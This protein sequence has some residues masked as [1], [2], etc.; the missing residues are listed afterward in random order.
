MAGEPM[1][2]TIGVPDL[3][4]PSYFPAIAAVELGFFKQRGL[5][6]EIRTIFP[7]ADTFRAQASGEID[8]VAG[9][10]H[11]ALYEYR[12]WVGCRLV[13]ALSQNMY[14]FL[15]VRSD[16]RVERGELAGVVGLRI[17]AAPGPVDGLRE[18]LRLAGIDPDRDVEIVPPKGGSSI[19]FGVNAARS[20]EDG[21]VDAFWA[22]GMGARVAVDGG[23]GTVVIDARRGDGPG[24]S[25]DFTFPALVATER[26]LV[27]SADM[28]RAAVGAVTDA[29]HALKKE[30]ERAINAA[31]D[32]FP[33]SEKSQISSLV[34]T[35]SPFYDPAI[36]M[37]KVAS[38]NEFS[39]R[40]GL[41]GRE[42]SY[43]EVVATD[44]GMW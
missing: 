39:R 18:M 35:D 8:F 19:S 20:L 42:V 23:F 7:I 30:P 40:I 5:P 1:S 43:D 24:G 3:I 28:V 26:Q 15:V 34:R 25:T 10:A 32:H 38:L 22:N 33:E 44:L 29:Q 16:M 2:V 13:C 41:L 9:A 37:Q 17:A 4:S 21:H 14:W 27:D 11:A 36:S 12:D 6:A 31:E